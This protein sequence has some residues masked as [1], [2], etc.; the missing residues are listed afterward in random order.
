[1][2]IRE[3]KQIEDFY[4]IYPFDRVSG[5]LYFSNQAQNTIYK[6]ALRRSENQMKKTRTIKS[7]G[8]VEKLKIKKKVYYI[9]KLEG[10]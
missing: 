1:M 10:W 9:I 7:F 5:A 6:I 3:E 2:A 4:K 8:Q